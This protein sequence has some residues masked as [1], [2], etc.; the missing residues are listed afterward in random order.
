MIGCS[1]ASIESRNK[2]TGG[3]EKKEISMKNLP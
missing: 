3:I 1:K 2:S